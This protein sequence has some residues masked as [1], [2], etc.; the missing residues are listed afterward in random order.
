[1][2]KVKRV[3]AIPAALGVLSLALVLG[4][5]QATTPKTDTPVPVMHTDLV[6]SWNAEYANDDGNR[7][8]VTYE[9]Y[10]DQTFKRVTTVTRVTA[11]LVVQQQG[12]DAEVLSRTVVTGTWEV[13]PGEDDEDDGGT[14]ELQVTGCVGDDCGSGV[15]VGDTFEVSYT[16]TDDG[17]IH[18]EVAPD[19]PATR[20]PPPAMDPARDLVGTYR[21]QIDIVEGGSLET[22]TLTF[23][24][25]RWIWHSTGVG[26]Q[27][28]GGWSVSGS[29]VTKTW[30]DWDTQSIRSVAKQL[31]FDGTDLI[32]DPWDWSDPSESV[33]DRERYTKVENPL[34]SSM[35]GSW[36]GPRYEDI[37][38]TST[39]TETWRFILRAD[40]TVTMEVVPEP[41]FILT[42]LPGA[43]P[44]PPQCY[45]G[46]LTI[47]TSELFI[48]FT[49]TTSNARERNDDNVQVF[50]N[51]TWRNAYA[52]T[53]RQDVIVMSTYWSE[54]LW[55]G[56]AAAVWRDNPRAPYGNYWLPLTR[57]P[58]TGREPCKW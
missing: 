17:M 29:T 48:T 33:E 1:M 3:A 11:Q 2:K 4:G 37:D 45:H 47:D 53:D 5:C 50:E 26:Y 39:F 25:S 12:D 57:E 14:V 16:A 15:D 28:S 34:P 38:G 22:V 43:D 9:L 51:K 56:E 20:E 36:A 18:L 40:G 46:T 8:T 35:I 7:V 6:G 54:Q 41:E 32:V 19:T 21:A 10:D 44:E 27:Q 30:Y 24:P 42:P 13:K 49:D 23:T 58:N 55:P 52:P 31:S